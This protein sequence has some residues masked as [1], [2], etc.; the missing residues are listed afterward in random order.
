VPEEQRK[1]QDPRGH[2]KRVN[3]VDARTDGSCAWPRDLQV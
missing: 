2:E 3:E 1:P